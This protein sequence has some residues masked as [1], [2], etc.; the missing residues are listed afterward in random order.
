MM[1]TSLPITAETPQIIAPP[2]VAFGAPVLCP[3]NTLPTGIFGRAGAI[4]DNLGLRCTPFA[5]R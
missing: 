4:V 2:N 5:I 3:P 1:G